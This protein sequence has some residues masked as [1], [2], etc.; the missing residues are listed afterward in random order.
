MSSISITTGDY[1]VL[2]NGSVIS[3]GRT[4]IEI[5]FKTKEIIGSEDD[6]CL[7]FTFHDDESKNPRIE[8]QVTSDAKKLELKLFN[9]N[10]SIDIG[11]VSPLMIGKTNDEKQIALNYRS[12]KVGD[13]W[14]LEY[15]IYQAKR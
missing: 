5:K 15:T 4:P 10:S 13:S 3:Y 11:N 6:L 7:V 8:T 2:A 9:F 1:E 14:N 12:R